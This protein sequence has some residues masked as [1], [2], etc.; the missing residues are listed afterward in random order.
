MLRYA[1]LRYATLSCGGSRWRAGLCR[2]RGGLAALFSSQMAVERSLM[3][4]VGPAGGRGAGRL[5]QEHRFYKARWKRE[6]SLFVKTALLSFI[7]SLMG[8]QF[9][10]E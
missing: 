3:S 6:F 1:M 5:P 2:R 10:S 4:P 9:L 8:T 7:C